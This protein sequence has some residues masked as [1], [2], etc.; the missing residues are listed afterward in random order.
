VLQ[1]I[2][3]IAIAL[4]NTWGLLLL[5][6]LLGHGLVD[7]PR[8]LW[9]RSN[10]QLMMRHYLF[11]LS[12]YDQKLQEA[13]QYL[14]KQLRKVRYVDQNTPPMSPLRRYVDELLMNA[15]FE[16]HPE[17]SGKTCFSRCALLQSYGNNACLLSVPVFL[18]I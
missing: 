13:K 16:Q 1:D 9:R 7:V 11:E 10:K 2:P 15:P 18:P 8:T 3:G 17:A 12:R 6:L 4:S 14:H 5:I